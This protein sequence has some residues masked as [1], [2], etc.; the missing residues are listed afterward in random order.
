MN[1]FE[2]LEQRQGE[3]L[4]TLVKT[5]SWFMRGPTRNDESQILDIISEML[6]QKVGN[7]GV[8]RVAGD[9]KKPSL[10]PHGR[11]SVFAERGMLDDPEFTLLLY[12]HIDTVFPDG[13]PSQWTNPF[14]LQKDGDKFSGLGVYD[15]KAG[16][17]EIID[18]FRETELPK[19]LRLQ[20]ALCH[21]EEMESFGALDLVTWLKSTDRVPDLIL[22]PEIATLPK[23]Q[24]T[25]SPRKDIIANRIGHAKALLELIVPQAHRFN[26]KALD[27]EHELNYVRNHLQMHFEK[28]KVMHENFG[29]MT[30]DF[31]F[32]EAHVFRAVGFSNTTKGVLRT[33]YLNMPGHSL[34]EVVDWQMKRVEECAKIRGWT[35]KGLISIFNPT[36]GETSYEPYALNLENHTAKMVLDGVADVYGAYKLKGGGSTSDANIFNAQL[37]PCYDIGPVGDSAHNRAEWVSGQS[38][39]KNMEFIRHMIQNRIPALFEARK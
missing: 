5:P 14:H 30:E 13:F 4:E 39:V 1:R 10:D 9:P 2:P 18:I 38:M 37:A 16:A 24:E 29:K 6:R 21:D 12:A 34:Q 28:D 36:H 20:V 25:D 15:M 8:H 7:E 33:S 19:G 3:I 35:R 22:S 32:T 26:R 17:M 23:R 11:K 27:A 31:R